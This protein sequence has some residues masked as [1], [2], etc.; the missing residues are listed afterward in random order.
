VLEVVD[1][2]PE[3]SIPLAA[4][5]LGKALLALGPR[6]GAGGG[7]GDLPPL[8][9][10]RFSSLTS[11][12]ALAVPGK[13][14]HPLVLPVMALS[15]RRGGVMVMVPAAYREMLGGAVLP[16]L[17]MAC[18]LTMDAKSYKA[19]GRVE[20]LG[21]RLALFLEAAYSAMPP[22]VGEEI[23]LVRA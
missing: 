15:T 13:D 6:P 10:R 12:K 17:G 2:L 20:R 8:V 14:G 11:V 5:I 23:E 22:L 16:A 4:V 18:L 1:A 9:S 3:T 19:E 7:R 21:G